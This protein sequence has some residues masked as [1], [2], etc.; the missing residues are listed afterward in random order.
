MINL[1][2]QYVD[3]TSKYTG[4]QTENNPS[5]DSTLEGHDHLESHFIG[6][7]QCNLSSHNMRMN[8][9]FDSKW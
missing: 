3:E 9:L 7:V 6:K 8:S 5:R 4:S 1:A 2:F